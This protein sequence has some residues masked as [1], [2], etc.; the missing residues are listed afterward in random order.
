MPMEIDR[1]AFISSLGGVAV[2]SRMSHEARADALEDYSIV[3]L[4]RQVAY[5]QA[6]QNAAAPE[7]FPTTA[8]LEARI[9]GSASR[10]GVGNLFLGTRDRPVKRLEPMP[11][12]P[13]LIDFFNLRFKTAGAYNHV[14]QS[15]TRAMKT[16][17][18]EEVI[19]ACLL[20]DVV[21]SLIK[22]DHGWWGAQMF[23]PY[24]PEKST[25]G[26][27]Y[28]QALRFYADEANG[29]EYPDLYRRTFG[30]DYTPEP[31]IEETYKMVRKHKWYSEPRMV[32]VNDLYAFDPNAVVTMDP[33]VDIVGRHFKQ[34][35]E[36]L[37]FDNSPVAHMWRSIAY[38]DHPL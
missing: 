17:M 10:R 26:I 20:H 16:G 8:E 13:T 3:E 5:A 4:D 23:E 28:H 27:R 7:H 25:F 1:R 33:F 9:D 38:P 12:R 30:V 34:P 21:Q 2:V 14:L 15:A 19:F 37:G 36:G 35:K 24:I 31:Y 32:T 11:K 22:V 18:T 29:Y 6:G